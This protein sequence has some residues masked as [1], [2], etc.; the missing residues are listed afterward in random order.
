M[1]GG[2]GEQL[3]GCSNGSSENPQEWEGRRRGLSNEGIQVSIVI[4]GIW[5][6][7]KMALALESSLNSE[8]RGRQ[9]GLAGRGSA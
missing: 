5:W 4:N 2:L 1:A 8:I 9:A 3:R 6:G 7:E